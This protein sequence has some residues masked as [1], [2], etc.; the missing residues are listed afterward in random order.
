[1]SA[2]KPSGNNTASA[3]DPISIWRADKAGAEIRQA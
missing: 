3:R 1:M 2:S